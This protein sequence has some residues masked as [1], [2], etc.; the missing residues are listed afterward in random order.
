[1]ADAERGVAY[2]NRV[3]ESKPFLVDPA[4]MVDRVIELWDEGLKPGDSTGWPSLDRFFTV[5]PGRLTVVTGWPSSGK[6]EWLDAML[7]HLAKQGWCTSI[8]SPEKHPIELHMSH[9]LEKLC[10]QPFAAGATER[11]PRTSI[12]ERAQF[13]RSR[14]RFMD[15]PPETMLS[16]RAIV[17]A[18]APWLLAQ[19]KRIL[20]MD[21]WNELEHERP[22]HLSETEY[23]SQTLSHLR[24][25]AK[26]NGVHIFIV[27]HPQ[28]MRLADG[29]LP[30]PRPDMISGSQ[31]WWNK[32]DAN[33]A[34]HRD[35]NS[36][37]DEVQ[38]YVQKCRG[39]HIGRQGMAIL[40]WDKVT[41]RYFEQPIHNYRERN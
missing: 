23:V 13:L 7:I 9:M 1:M 33:L 20:V 37:S 41:G 4:D 12:R 8:Y 18:A 39:K 34:I 31:N 27:A 3:V 5:T 6:S 17:D 28:K 35:Q 22:Q 32:P 29:T 11:I 38:V 30:V 24:R 14:F 40:K 19:A 15:S 16:P 10:G 21:P 36:D 26:P 25:W 2:L